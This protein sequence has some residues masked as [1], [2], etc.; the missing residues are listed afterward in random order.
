MN[1][2]KSEEQL[3]QHLW[4]LEKAFMKDLMD[5]YPEPKPAS[6]TVATLLKRLLDKGAIGFNKYG[7]VREYFPILK[8]ED[9]SS[10]QFSGVMKS[11]FNDSVSQFASFFT[12]RENLSDDELEEL[13]KIVDDQIKNRKQ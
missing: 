12:S 10:K 9:Y 13:R 6:T 1:L 2:P 4:T 11:F 8:K 3:M 5:A 7:N